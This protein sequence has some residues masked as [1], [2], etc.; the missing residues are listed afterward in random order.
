MESNRILGK[1]AAG[2]RIW[3]GALETL[4][5]ASKIVAI[6]FNRR[7]A[8]AH[9]WLNW[10]ERAVDSECALGLFLAPVRYAKELAW[11]HP[12]RLGDLEQRC[13]RR[14]PHPTLNA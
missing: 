9:D 13:D 7:W 4:A 6:R 3:L 2:P 12:K 10:R 5:I 8:L 14:I 11:L 1:R